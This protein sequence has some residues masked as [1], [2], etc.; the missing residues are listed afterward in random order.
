M[1]NKTRMRSCLNSAAILLIL[2]QS[3]QVSA[4]TI[5]LSVNPESCLPL[6]EAA[7]DHARAVNAAGLVAA[8]GISAG[9]GDMEDETCFGSLNDLSFDWFQGMPSF[10]SI[11]IDALK[12]KALDMITNMACD[13]VSEFTEKAQTLLS[14]SASLG[15][16]V[17]LGV[18]GIDL[19][20]VE[21]CG[22]VTLDYSYDESFGDGDY[23]FEASE[24]TSGGGGLGDYGTSINDQ[25]DLETGKPVSA[26]DAGGYW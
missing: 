17:G 8:D 5:A 1:H 4:E 22:G 11:A 13:A 9:E 12:D 23:G 21:A 18:N 6:L 10:Q 2:G 7:D 24:E 16:N 20:D 15:V 3:G 19:P 26:G 25:I 14:C